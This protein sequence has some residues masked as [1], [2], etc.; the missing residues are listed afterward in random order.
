MFISHPLN[1]QP[2]RP[3]SSRLQRT[4]LTIHL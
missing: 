1:Q 4:A 2:L 3:P